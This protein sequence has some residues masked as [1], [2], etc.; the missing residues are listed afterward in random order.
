MLRPE[1]CHQK[2]FPHLWPA[3]NCWR[4]ST[5][6]LPDGAADRFRSSGGQ[7]RLA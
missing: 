5:D 6:A 1:G 7:H 4:G 3:W 2:E